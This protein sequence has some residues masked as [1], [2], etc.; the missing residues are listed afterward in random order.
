MCPLLSGRMTG[1]RSA[2][3]DAAPASVGQREA[4]AEQQQSAA[5]PVDKLLDQFLLRRREVARLHRADDQPLVAEKIFGAA[6]ESRR[7]VPSDRRCPGDRFCFRWC[8]A[9]RRSAT[10][11]SSS[12]ARRMN[13]YSQRGSPST[14]RMRRLS[15]TTFTRRVTALLARFCFARQRVDRELQRLRSGVAGVEENVFGLDFAVAGKCDR[16]RGQHFVAIAHVERGLLPG[17]A[18]LVES[19]RCGEPRIRQR[20]RRDDGVVDFHVVRDLLPR[21]SRRCARECAGCAARRSCRDRCRR[22][23]RRRR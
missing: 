15:L 19:D 18:A 14:Y 1:S 17:V 20:A 22:N 23:C 16:L 4:P 5:A 6:R 11:R 12:S 7:R 21:R 2:R 10:I 8:A 13:L 9:W 3:L